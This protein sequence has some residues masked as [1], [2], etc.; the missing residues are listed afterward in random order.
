MPGKRDVIPN[1]M[2][3]AV[4]SM[5]IFGFNENFDRVVKVLKKDKIIKLVLCAYLLHFLHLRW[6]TKVS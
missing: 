6:R 4:T 1:L 5:F 2:K 3:R